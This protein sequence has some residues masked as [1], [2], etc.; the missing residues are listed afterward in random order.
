VAFVWVRP[1]EYE[2]LGAFLADT[3]K[4]AGVTQDELAARLQKP[5]S[6]ISAYER[7]QRRVDILELMLIFAMLGIDP[8]E[9][10]SEIVALSGKWSTGSSSR[11][12]DNSD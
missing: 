1:A 6:F 3:R 10:L 11:P 8:L 12:R 9:A 5:Q 4:K 2:A 7:G